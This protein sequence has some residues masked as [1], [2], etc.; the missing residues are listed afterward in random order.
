MPVRHERRAVPPGHASVTG[1]SVRDARTLAPQAG[2][3]R[4]SIRTVRFLTNAQKSTEADRMTAAL[5]AVPAGDV[6]TV[7]VVSNRRPARI[8]IRRRSE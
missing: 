1:S 7:E 3:V 6:V 5:K 2:G 8:G 4:S